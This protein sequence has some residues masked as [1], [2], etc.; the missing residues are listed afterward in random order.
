MIIYETRSVTNRIKEVKQPY[1]GFIKPT[2]FAV[3]QL[4]D[5]KMLHEK[6]SV[7]S[8]I[9]G[10]VVDYLTRYSMNNDVEDA[11]KISLQGA[12]I[13][14]Y[15]GGVAGSVFTALSFASD[16]KGLDDSSIV[17]ACKLVTFDVWRRSFSTA[18][19]CRTYADTWVDANTI[20]NIRTLVNRSIAFFEAYGPV[21]QSDFEFSPPVPDREAYGRLI[22][23]R[24]GVYGGYTP[25]VSGGDGD[26]LTS[27]TLW[28]FKCSKSKPT[29]KHTLQLLM[30]WIMGQ[31]S[32]Q[33]VYK[34]I[35]KLGIYNP[36]LNCVYR[37]NMSDVP[38]DVIKTVEKDVICY[39]NI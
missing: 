30:Y 14:E 36:R 6:E 31:H 17:S 26:F 35:T 20:E 19:M 39:E 34:G 22:E 33:D 16:I 2:A 23:T 37:M 1:G 11:F 38:D 27:D 18:A 15:Q 5:G 12:N 10:L 3:T 9:V 8:S 4:D 13:A 29:S 21:V 25:V 32:G 24:T 7:H 28:D